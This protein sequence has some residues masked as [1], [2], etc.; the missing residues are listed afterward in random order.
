MT[1]SAMA[2]APICSASASSRS[3]RRAATTTSNPS[4]ASRRAVAAPMPLLAPVTT[5]VP[6]DSPDRDERAGIG[7]DM[8]HIL[9]RAPGWRA[10]RGIGND[11]LR[12]HAA[13]V[14]VSRSSGVA[15]VSRV[16]CS[17]RVAMLSVHTSPLDQPGTGDAGGMNVY[18]V[19]LA[20]RLAGAGIDVE[21]FTRATRGG[22]PPVVELRRRRAA[23][24]T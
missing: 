20:K 13:E 5:A 24:A 10:R 18:V 16:G 8:G 2:R 14:S 6:L 15:S 3:V 7:V 4:A 23:C 21:I 1:S 11:R 9:A 22:L 12:L 19:E 17:R